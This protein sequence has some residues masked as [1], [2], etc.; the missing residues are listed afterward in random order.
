MSSIAVIQSLASDDFVASEVPS[1]DE[2]LRSL[3]TRGMNSL[4]FFLSSITPGAWVPRIVSV[5]KGR[6]MLGALLL[7]ERRIGGIPSGLLYGDA[8][9]DNLVI[10]SERYR[11]AV[12]ETTLGHMLSCPG[13][14]GIRLAIPP[15]GYEARS[16]PAIC[17]KRRFEMF[18]QT[19]VNHLSLPLQPV[20]ERFV[21]SL[22]SKT[23][24]N[25]RYY[26]RRAEAL[27]HQYV[28]Q[29]EE[30]EFQSAIT[31]LLSKGVTGASHEGVSRALR[32]FAAVERPIFSGLRGRDGEWLAVLGG[33]YDA[34]RA[35]LFLQM[36]A[37][38]QRPAESLSLVLRAHFIENLIAEGVRSLVFWAGVGLPISRYCTPVPTQRIYLDSTSIGWRATRSIVKWSAS[39]LPTLASGTGGWIV[40]MSQPEKAESR[41]L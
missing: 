36:N 37:E 25:V 17:E 33:W 22:G 31:N 10:S 41:L 30:S 2:G 3:A 27:G 4:S 18:S 13:V 14:R 1:T 35:V 8:T 40:P 32:I 12:F 23:R 24:R 16:L 15:N 7:K 11:E 6:D 38:F 39:L 29:M 26:R 28:H 34:H 9:L 5:R 19:S 20:Y 21:E